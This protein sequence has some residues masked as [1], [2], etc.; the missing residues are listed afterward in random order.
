MIAAEY[1]K[2]EGLLRRYLTVKYG[3]NEAAAE[4]KMVRFEDAYHDLALCRQMMESIYV[5]SG[6]NQLTM[7]IKEIYNL[8]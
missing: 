3:G 6:A 2:Y 5:Y 8:I 1:L 4:A 7:L